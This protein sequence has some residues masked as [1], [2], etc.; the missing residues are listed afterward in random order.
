MPKSAPIGPNS[1]AN[2]VQGWKEEDFAETEEDQM[3]DDDE[4]PGQ[5]GVNAAEGDFFGAE[6]AEQF[7]GGEEQ[8]GHSA[9]TP[10]SQPEAET[11]PDSPPTGAGG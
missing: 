8:P 3:R 6:A 11:S 1:W 2:V 5:E 7:F 4:K 10:W 9:A